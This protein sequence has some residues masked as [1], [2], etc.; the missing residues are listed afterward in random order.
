MKPISGAVMCQ[1]GTRIGKTN[2][3]DS[4][5][6]ASKNVALPI[7]TRARTNQRDVGICSMRVISAAAASPEASGG[8]G[9]ET[10]GASDRDPALTTDKGSLPF[11]SFFCSLLFRPA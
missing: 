8:A 9:D 1:S 7:T 3:I 6:N 2:A 5:L 11:F 4:A 10:A